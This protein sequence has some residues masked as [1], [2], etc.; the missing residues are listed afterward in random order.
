MTFRGINLTAAVEGA[1]I[2]NI[3]RPARPPRERNKVIIP[4]KDGSYDFGNNRIEDFLVSAEIVITATSASELQTKIQALSAF[5]DGKGGLVFSDAPST[6][7]QAQVYD[8]VAV[9]GDTTARWGRA[10]V[11]FECD[12]GG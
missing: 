1:R 2:T 10:L 4:G 9:V 6:V 5:L 8:E 11:V 3:S 12:A 7:Y